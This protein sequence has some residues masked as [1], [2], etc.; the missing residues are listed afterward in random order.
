MVRPYVSKGRVQLLPL[1]LGA[2]LFLAAG[3]AGVGAQSTATG[4]DTSAVPA[5]QSMT[6]NLAECLQLASQRQPRVAAQRASLAAAEDGSQ[7]LENLQ[8]PTVL[9]PD[10]PFRR[11]QAALGVSAAA[12]GVEQAEHEAAY[13]V[14]RTYFTVL[15]AREQERVAQSIAERLTA[16]RDSAKRS[17]DAGARD[18]SAADVNRASIFLN[19]ARTRRTQAGQGV[20]RALVALKEA[21]GLRP[22][23]GLEVPAS[24]LPDVDVRP[25]RVE[26]VAQAVSRRAELI[27]AGVL[28][29][30]TCL[31]ADAQGTRHH[32]RV[33][34]F[35][36]GSDI[37]GV[38]VSQGIQNMEYRPGAVPPEMPSLLVGSRAD[39]VK[40]AQ[41]FHAR[42]QA[43][44]ETAHNLVVLE[45]EDAF[46]RW[47]EASL[48]IPE[49]REASNASE[50]LADDVSKDFTAG[51]RVKVEDVIN[52]RVLASQARVQYNDF[53]YRQILAL[54]DLERITGGAFNARLAEAVP[55]Q[56][57]AA[58]GQR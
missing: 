52:A 5:G 7:A 10:L 53:L 27:R 23:E 42:A 35:A 19:L 57:A 50:K 30:V 48:Q 28:V 37:H 32:K 26:I 14:T 20:K 8:I 9:V 29:D 11:K 41:S 44:A 1:S 12:A 24:Q 39:R 56:P 38:Q 21:I 46:L 47:E 36:A 22:E 18:V 58:R 43:V 4:R 49:A 15:Y 51:L 6:L 40:R 13:A 17:L 16:T 54:A 2:I 34:T 31:E 3:R 33:E 55:A 45:A 25:A